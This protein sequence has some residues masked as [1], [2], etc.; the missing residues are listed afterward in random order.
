MLH[1]QLNWL[2]PPLERESTFW[3]GE[4]QSASSSTSV[5]SKLSL[6]AA[7]NNLSAVTPSQQLSLT[8]V[9]INSLDS[10][11]E[12]KFKADSYKTS[13]ACSLLYMSLSSRN[14]LT[15][16]RGDARQSNQR[17]AW[18]VMAVQLATATLDSEEASDILAT[19]PKTKAL[20][21]S[22]GI[23][24]L[25]RSPR[26]V[27]CLN[28]SLT[29]LSAFHTDSDVP[30][31]LGSLSHA[32]TWLPASACC[33]HSDDDEGLSCES[34]HHLFHEYDIRQ[35]KMVPRSVTNECKTKLSS[36]NC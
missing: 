34:H 20:R 18:V 29:I 3:F 16:V 8:N 31:C 6:I 17:A 14:V 35:R 23:G 27:Q 7:S 36:L 21:S 5:G 28:R 22:N 32:A 15:E 30:P 12:C 11:A 19:N 10:C 1:L 13:M 9:Q 25:P 33:H 24:C 26:V 4:L 2:P